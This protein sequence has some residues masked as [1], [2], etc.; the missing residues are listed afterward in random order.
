MSCFRLPD[1]LLKDIESL[2]AEFF[3]SGDLTAKIDWLAWDSLCQSK[4]E[5]GLGLR[6]LKES[7]I[8]L[9]AKQAWR[10]AFTREGILQEVLGQ[11]YFPSSNFFEDRLGSRPS[12]TWHSLL[13][14]RYLLV[15]GL[16]W[17]GGDGAS[18]PISGQP[19]LP[20]PNTFQ[21]ITKPVSLQENS[22]AEGRVMGLSGILRDMG[23]SQS[24]VLTRLLWN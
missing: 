16:R 6:C 20:R 2:V 7:N 4:E 8:A 18:I 3:W 10:I 1:S 15:A 14:T 17:R 24:A 9:L 23:G 11:K 21:L 13:G 5:G 19:W 12:F 22:K